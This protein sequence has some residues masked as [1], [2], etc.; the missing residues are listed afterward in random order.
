MNYRTIHLTIDRD[1]ARQRIARRVPEA[2]VKET[3]GQV[4]FRT[5]S[6]LLLAVLSDDERGSKLRYRT[7]VISSQLV[8]AR[9]MARRIR[10]AVEAYKR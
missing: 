7:A 10:G 2:R 3:D 5:N 6:G 8:H 4:E 9:T 1:E